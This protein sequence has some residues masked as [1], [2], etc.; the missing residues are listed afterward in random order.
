VTNSPNNLKSLR[1]KYFSS[2]PSLGGILR[3]VII[4]AVVVVCV[5]LFVF[6]VLPRI[7]PSPAT[8][9]PSATNLDSGQTISIGVGWKGGAAPYTIYLYSSTSGSC[10]S[11]STQAGKETPLS[12]PQFIF[13]VAPTVN[14]RYCGE[15][16][17]SKGSSTMSRTVLI[18]VNPALEAPTLT[19]SPSAMDFNQT[20]TVIAK[21][22][23]I[24]G[25]APYSFA[26]HSG[27][28]KTCSA[29]K[30]SV[31]VS[32]GKNPITGLAGTT[33]QFSF[34][35]PAVS[36]FYC[37]TVTNSAAALVPKTSLVAEFVVSPALK[38]V[39]LHA[40]VKLDSGQS[41]TLSAK[42]VGGTL[43]YVYQWYSGAACVTP[44]TGQTKSTFPTGALTSAGK[45]SVMVKD[46]SAALPVS[47]ICINANIAVS[48]KFTGTKVAIGPSVAIDAGQTANLTVSWEKAGTSP[49]TVDLTTSSSAD[50]SSPSPTGQSVTGLTNTSVVFP[51]T[52]ASGAMPNYCA[53][54]TD[55]ATTPESAATSSA[56]SI[57]VN[58]TLAATIALSTPAVDIG[59]T[60]TLSISVGLSGGTPPYS[61]ALYSGA[62]SDCSSDTT[63]VYTSGGNPQTAVSGPSATFSVTSPWTTTY[64][65]AVVNDAAM[66]FANVPTSS[67]EFVVNSGLYATISPASPSVV[68]GHSITL[69]AAAGDGTSPYFYQWYNGTSCAAADELPGQTSV[70]LTTG[71]LTSSSEFSVSVTDSSPGTPTMHICAA[72]TVKVT[73]ALAPT[74]VLSPQAEDKGQFTT[75]TATVTLS[76]G[77]PPYT[78]TLYSGSSSSCASDTTK[79]AVITGPN[80]QSGIAGTSAAFTFSSPGSSTYYCARGTDSATTPATAS[81]STVLFTLNPPP[82]AVI[83]ISPTA[84][85]SGQASV[86]VTATVTWSGGIS[87]YTVTL[88]S[89]SSSSCA[90]DTTK[91]AVITGPNPQSGIAGT[92][93]AFT[94][95]SPGSSTYYCTSLTDG[96]S[97]PFTGSSATTL[98]TVNPALRDSF[99]LSPTVLDSGQSA[100]VSATVTWSGGTSL[101]TVTLYSGSSSSCASD[102][103]TVSVLSA[104]N[105]RTG[106][107]GTTAPFTFASPGSTTYYCAS[108]EDAS[109]EPATAMSSTSAFTVNPILAGPV[110]S[111]APSAI[112]SGQSATLSTATPFSG[113]TSAYTCQWLEEA[114]G[115]STF[116]DLGSSFSCTTASSPSVSTG[117]LST[118]NVWSFE[119]QVK[120]SSSTPVAVVSNVVTVTVSRGPTVVLSILPNVLDSGQ[121]STTVTATVTWSSG[122][123][124]YTVTLYSGSSTTCSSD[125]VVVTPL[126]GANPQTGLTLSSAAFTFSSPG[127]TTYYCAKLTDSSATPVTISSS[128]TAFTVNHAL[129]AGSLTLSPVVLDSGQSATVTATITWSGGTSHYSVTLYS[130][131]GSSC[132]S[133]TTVVSVLTSSNPLTGVVGTTGTFSFAS[134]TTSTYY[135]AAVKD[136]SAEPAT[137]L[138][139]TA[140]FTVN[141]SLVAP[142]ISAAPSGLDSGQ[143]AT[144]STATPFSG[145][146][147]AYTC[148]WLEEA[149]GASTFSDLGSSFSCTKT[150]LPSVSTGTLSALGIWSFDLQVKDSSS[151]PVTV[152]SNVATVTVNTSPSVTLSISPTAID[153]G[154]PSITVTAT[155]AWSGGTSP[156]TVSLYRGSSSTCSSD[157]LVVT[158]LS[159]TNPQTGLTAFS[160][161]FTFSSPGSTTY[162]CVKLT[163]SSPTPLTATSATS[164]F[165]VSPVLSV[166][167]PVLSP[168]T[169]DSG[170]STAVTATVTWSGGTSHYSVTLYSGS[171]SSCSSDTTVVSVLTSSNPLTGVVGTTG[172]FS[173][174]SPTTSTY[175]CAS[176]KD[177]SAE[178][179]TVLSGTTTFTVNPVLTAALAL[180]SGAIDSGQSATVTATVTWSGGTSTYSVALFSGISSSCASDTTAVGSAK[181]G[182]ISTSATFTFTSQASTTYYCAKVTDSSATPSTITTIP[183]RFTV[184]SP[185]T[186]AISPPAP[187]ISSGQSVNLTASS[188]LGTAPYTYK[189]YTGSSCTAVIS[190]Q[191]SSTYV[192]GALT[193]TSVF[194]VK[195]TDSSTGAPSSISSACASVTV[196]VGNGPEGIASDPTLGMVYVADPGSNN[197]TVIDSVSNTVVTTI[198]VGTLPWGIAVNPVTNLVYV[199]NYGSDTV[200]VIDGST[201]TVITTIVVGDQPE[202]IAVNPLLHTAYVADSGSNA[203]SVINTTAN[204]EISSIAVGSSPLSVA[205]GPSPTFTVFVTNY[206]SNTVSVMDVNVYGIPYGIENVAVG[207]NPWGI[208]VSPST[209]HVFVTN[210]GSGTVSVLNG[211]TLATLATLTVGSTPE[212]ITID[213][214]AS[215]AYV[216]DAGSNAISVIDTATNKVVTSTSPQIPIPV[217][218]NPSG[219]AILLNPNNALYPGQAYVTNSGTDTVSV[220]NIATSE[221]MTVIIVS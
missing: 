117:T 108:V 171:G 86:T 67:V 22:A 87:P 32:T 73:A 147:S 168:T 204:K 190:G 109:A 151:T 216:A 214:T 106:V 136:A 138:S 185:P 200:T 14:T 5:L 143:S 68:T 57:T 195:A 65:C 47:G 10:S 101:Y 148:Q 8:I 45:Y 19:L 118:L 120:D 43:P 63:L 20:A 93:A 193:T 177:A 125:T 196:T 2:M 30:T 159:G 212:G 221:V 164:P 113:G 35:A 95:S 166:G 201:N 160:T 210:S 179:V 28:S 213:S 80:P 137:I 96:G 55:S 29:D 128:T 25:A 59:Q 189:W 21:V 114:P 44:I 191:T 36:T 145:G 102:T 66:P 110:I 92:S 79:V 27:T 64:Y 154:Q 99:V 129:S 142:V 49:Y 127:S 198:G 152:T 176:V 188:S 182:L 7:L 132:S 82:T 100:T 9:T 4:A 217:G 40:S 11:S 139:G 71:L 157:T 133:D 112:D 184:N 181:A 107:T 39:L 167:T 81:S 219:V 33:A 161:A 23:A 207:S 163:D 94:F 104:S 13:T 119:L 149:P 215:I 135:C 116:S 144:L 183:A 34:K 78:V 131:S 122:T 103:T 140:L 206:G 172:T 180:S 187:S 72:T 1:A 197:I 111:V 208:A 121:P 48:A 75:V 24:G 170:Q 60:T 158:P 165:T 52:P 51:E 141:P 90:S 91:V 156:Y 211:S 62:S 218:A 26:L 70:S 175:Y 199:T 46:S 115:A 105:P 89:G 146:T 169:L 56:A 58:P 3:W 123:S 202:G 53:T 37:V 192:T 88:Y 203:V 205:V 15:V 186:V 84:V 76:G 50:C 31:V 97:P 54:I 61:V 153:S 98:F 209:N 130:G 126:S 174:A 38:A 42:A 134:P 155:V 194:S 83:A 150:S 17:S 16:S 173:F 162:Y 124:P 220:I 18:T 69:S 85:D 77:T 74:L 6:L 41:V 178:P 12:K